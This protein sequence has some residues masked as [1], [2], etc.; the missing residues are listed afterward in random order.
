MPK[1]SQ[2]IMIIAAEPSGDEL[3]AEL[4]HALQ[5]NDNSLIIKAI[6]LEKMAA[7]GFKSEISLDGLAILGLVEALGAWRKVVEKASQIGEIAK[8]FQPDKVIFID[9]WGFNLRAARAIRKTC[10]NA[11]LVKMVGPQVWATR[12]GRAKTVAQTYDEIWCIHEF[13]VPFYKDLGIKIEVIGNPAIGRAIIGNGNNFRRENGIEDE[14][15]LGL[16]PGSRKREIL[17]VAPSFIDAANQL[18]KKYPKL[19]IISVA[20]NSIKEQLLNLK[21]NAQFEWLIVDE[22]QKHDAFAAMDGALACSGTVTTELA[23]SKVP[24]L[25]GYRLDGLTYF[26]A[27]NFLLKSKFVCLLNVAMGREIVPELLQNALISSNII[28]YISKLIDDKAFRN[29]VIENQNQ[30]LKNMGQ[31]SKPTAMRAAEIILKK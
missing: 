1:K 20:A 22:T 24:M 18:A 31:G 30:A 2:K 8:G 15:I 6:G 23:L 26:I 21:S 17:N 12:A 27:R 13:E 16:L 14:F 10:P 5:E 7:L 29:Q 19:K 28:P 25:V 4:I 3:G 9:S 11:L